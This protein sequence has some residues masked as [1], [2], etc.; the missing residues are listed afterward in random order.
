M[1]PKTPGPTHLSTTPG[2]RYIPSRLDENLEFSRFKMATP[3]TVNKDEHKNGTS[4]GKTEQSRRVLM[5]QF[6]ALK[7]QKNSNR[8]LGL[9]SA[10]NSHDKCEEN[11]K[12]W[13]LIAYSEHL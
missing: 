1:M 10:P 8:L 5:D 11:G 2:S 7:G 13:V 3:D 4:G 6:L 9:T 12:S